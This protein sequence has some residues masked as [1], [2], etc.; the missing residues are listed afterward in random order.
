MRLV[1]GLQADAPV[2][3]ACPP[4]GRCASG[5]MRPASSASGAGLRGE[6]APA[7]RC[8]RPWA[9]RGWAPA[10]SRSV[11]RRAALRRRPRPRQ[12]PARRADG[13]GRPPA[14][15]PAAG[16]ARARAPAAQRASGAAVRFVLARS[17]SA[18][19]AVSQDTARRFNEGLERPIATHVY[20]SFD[21]ERFDPERVAPAPMR[22]ELGIA[23]RRRAARP[24]GAD[25]AL[26]GPGHLDPRPRRAAPRRA[27][28]APAARRRDRLRGHGGALR[29]PRLPARAARARRASW[30]WA[31]PS[32]SSASATTCPGILRAVDL[33]LLPSWDEPFANVML[34]SMAMG[35]PLL[36]SDVGG[37]PELVEDGVSGRLLPPRRPERW[38]AR[39]ARAARATGPR[40]PGWASARVRRTARFND[41]A[42][43]RDMLAVYARVLGQPR[44]RPRCA[45]PCGGKWPAGEGGAWPG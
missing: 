23:P 10:A 28:R 26:E 40:S 3:V 13:R 11:A 33:S 12:H 2:A 19:V 1:E 5:S 21:R 43:A 30:A 42:H 8:R 36:V 31:A 45:A 22:E 44:P 32:T 35:T 4:T 41:E 9:W 24:G 16:R 38:A 17:A 14:R 6:P 18:V 27:R 39:R 37:G 25:H 34:E 15:R 20:N 29:Q 7:N